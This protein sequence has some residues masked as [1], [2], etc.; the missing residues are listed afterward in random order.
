MNTKIELSIPQVVRSGSDLGLTTLV[1]APA[2]R[3]RSLVTKDTML[4]VQRA[5]QR[6]LLYYGDV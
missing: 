4:M 6:N 2:T 1:A 5:L 3:E